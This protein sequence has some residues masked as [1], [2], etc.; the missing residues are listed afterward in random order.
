MLRPS[1]VYGPGQAEKVGF[2]IIPTALGKLRRGETLHVWGDGSARR[3]YIFID[4]LVQLC[5]RILSRPMPAGMCVL[6]ACSGVSVSL[7]ELLAMME[8]VTGTAMPRTY[9]AARAVDA[10]NIA[11]D[12]R[13]AH[14]TYGW[15]HQTG[16]EEGI[17]RTWA[18]LGQDSGK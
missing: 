10:S 7:N 14:Q 17:A 12:P 15:R 2:A 16:L 13:L 6:N 3:D 9:D 5:M 11:M 8:S 18:W 4:D 1:N